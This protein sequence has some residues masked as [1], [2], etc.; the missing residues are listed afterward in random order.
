MEHLNNVFNK[1]KLF[2]TCLKKVTLAS[3]TKMINVF[4][5]YVAMMEWIFNGMGVLFTV[6]E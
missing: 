1:A 4:V 2:E 5:N 6:L 3:G